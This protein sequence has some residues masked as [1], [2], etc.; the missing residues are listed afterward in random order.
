MSSKE[1][2]EDEDD[3]V[4]RTMPMVINHKMGKKLYYVKDSITP[5]YRKPYTTYAARIRPKHHIMEFTKR[6]HDPKDTSSGR[7]Y[8]EMKYQTTKM[9]SKNTNLAIGYTQSGVFFVSPIAHILRLSPK[10]EEDEEDDGKNVTATTSSSSKN[11]SA[12]VQ[13][14][15]EKQ[16]TVKQEPVPVP[17]TV[18]IKA[19]R[20]PRARYANR[21]RKKNFKDLRKEI[22]EDHWVDL[23][24]YVVL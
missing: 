6:N 9:S 2:D 20:H 10:L 19:Q 15:Q 16:D 23:K 4:V 17:V 1:L 3:P 14:K 22:S 5:K 24:V 21:V 11:V 12:A 18:N 13:V 7:P 8:H